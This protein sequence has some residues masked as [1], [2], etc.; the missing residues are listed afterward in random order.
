[1]TLIRPHVTNHIQM[2]RVSTQLL[3]FPL[4]KSAQSRISRYGEIS[5]VK[6]REQNKQAHGM[7]EME[8]CQEILKIKNSRVFTKVSKYI[9]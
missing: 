3:C 2:F 5:V 4:L 6:Y 7:K 8:T 1:M 9:C